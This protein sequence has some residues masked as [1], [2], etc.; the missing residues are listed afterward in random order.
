MRRAPKGGQ[1]N[2]RGLHPNVFAV[3]A[4]RDGAWAVVSKW[5]SDPLRKSIQADRYAAKHG[6]RARTAHKPDPDW[7]PRRARTA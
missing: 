5:G 7:A 1:V 3:E 2:N 6:C 4:F